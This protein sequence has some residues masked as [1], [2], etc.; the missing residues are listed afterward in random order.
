LFVDGAIVRCAELESRIESAARQLLSVSPARARR[1][2]LQI[3]DPLAFL[4][5]LFAV[6][7]I[8][9]A[10][11]PLPAATTPDTIKQILL[12][13]RPDFVVCDDSALRTIGALQLSVPV[14]AA[15]ELE[16]QSAKGNTRELPLPAPD[17]EATIL[18]SSGTTERPKG[19]I[20][21]H[22]ARMASARIQIDQWKMN[23]ESR[24]W[25]ASPIYMG[26]TLAPLFAT[27]LAGGAG[28]VMSKFRVDVMMQIA[29]DLRPPTLGLVPTQFLMLLSERQFKPTLLSSCQFVICGGSHLDGS[30]RERLF[31]Y[32][33]ETFVQV[34][35]S[36]ETDFISAL[37]RDSLVE[38]RGSV[39]VR[40]SSVTVKIIGGD[41]VVMRAGAVG[42]IVVNSPALMK[43]YVDEGAKPWW[44]DDGT[45]AVYFRTGDLGS[46][47]ADGYLWIAG[48]IK[49]MIVCGGR[50]V[51]PADVEAVLSRHPAIRENVVIGVTHRVLGEVPVAF[52]LRD[53]TSSAA[54]DEASLLR[55]ANARLSRHQILHGL[56]IVSSLP[57]NAA[58]KPAHAELRRLAQT[59][60]PSTS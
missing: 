56:F 33:P 60:L 11:V 19:V 57:R 18:Y 39:G 3:D 23:K 45:G 44:R 8:G 10:A 38:K 36:T 55:W 54:V 20:H 29:A 15:R 28:I 34:Y 47:D 25:L 9:A 30:L 53:A 12:D 7:R 27:L 16:T 31:E 37:P 22:A 2:A 17:D 51:F 50:N 35:G 43:G 46:I 24:T 49:E 58:G 40:P 52:V 26:A 13:C 5:T 42:E 32:F 4:G 41:G 59:R 14:V 6:M 21:T 48:R 1:V